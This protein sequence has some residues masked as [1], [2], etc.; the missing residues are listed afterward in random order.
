MM[1][2]NTCLPGFHT[3]KYGTWCDVNE[4]CKCDQTCNIPGGLIPGVCSYKL[5]SVCS[6][7]YNVCRGG[8]CCDVNKDCACDQTCVIPY[9]LRVCSYRI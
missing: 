9:G 6:P 3:C 4:D 5:S 2:Q 8:T 1:E 7:G